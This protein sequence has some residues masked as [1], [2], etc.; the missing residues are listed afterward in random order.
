V[1]SSE[2]TINSTSRSLL[3]KLP[4]R[5]STVVF[6]FYMSAIMAT[7]MCLVITAINQGFG[8]GYLLNVM[9]A[10]SLAMPCAFMF[11]LVVKPIVQKL[12]SLTVHSE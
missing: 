5:A 2:T 6:S 1:N 7:L 10:Y 9:H 12:V 11:I 4:A 8:E 3:R